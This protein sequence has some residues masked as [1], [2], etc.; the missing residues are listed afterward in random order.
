MNWLFNSIVHV[1]KNEAAI[2][3]AVVNL[4]KNHQLQ[5]VRSHCIKLLARIS[6]DVNQA[7]TDILIEILKSQ[8][9]D[10]DLKNSALRAIGIMGNKNPAIIKILNQ[11]VGHENDDNSLLASRILSSWIDYPSF[12]IL[13]HP[14]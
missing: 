5:E 10:N 4:I 3:K 12:Y 11:L 14:N 2:I 8:E 6:N 13:C 9:Y 7:S 1:C